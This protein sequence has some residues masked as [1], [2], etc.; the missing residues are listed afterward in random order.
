MAKL[1]LKLK[2]LDI[3]S[4][5]GEVYDFTIRVHRGCCPRALAEAEYPAQLDNGHFACV[6]VEDGMADVCPFMEKVQG[7]TVTCGY[8]QR[9]PEDI[10][11]FEPNYDAQRLTI[12]AKWLI[13]ILDADPDDESEREEFF[14]AY[15]QV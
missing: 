5:D 8:R 11:G 2:Q 14:S 10:L 6:S 3:C 15:A 12:G 9:Q 4:E 7:G 1:R 13:D